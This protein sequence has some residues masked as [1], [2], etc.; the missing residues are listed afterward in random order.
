MELAGDTN[1]GE[2]TL[3]AAFNFSFALRKAAPG[4][5]RLR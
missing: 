2:I 5:L 4:K 3:R 1:I